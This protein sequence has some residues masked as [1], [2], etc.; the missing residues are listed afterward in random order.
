MYSVTIGDDVFGEL[1]QLVDQGIKLHIYDHLN[2]RDYLQPLWKALQYNL[3]IDFHCIFRAS[4]MNGH[5]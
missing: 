3:E 4:L 5:D 2:K 1:V